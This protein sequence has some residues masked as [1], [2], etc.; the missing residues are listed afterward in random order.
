MLNIVRRA[1]AI[2]AALLSSFVSAQAQDK[3]TSW[4]QFGDREVV[5]LAASEPKPY[6]AFLA[7]LRHMESRGN[8]RAVNTLN[9]LGAYQFG[10]AAL[11]DLGYVRRDRNI[12]DNNFGGGFTG[13]DGI[14]SV[15]DFLNNPRVQ[16]KAARNWVKLMW[17]YIESEGLHRY[18]W[19]RTGD[20]VLTPSG[21]L[22]ATH[23][24]GTGG[25]RK[26]IKSGGSRKIVDP[27]GT[28]IYR[29]VRTLAGYEIP[30]APKRPAKLASL[31]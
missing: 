21:M 18:A 16:D 24:L 19:T 1:A 9:F 13:K 30:F 6:D 26:F 22:G 27:Y 12:S 7:E 8:Y 23:L 29:Y 11:I 14:R 2:S 5:V 20:V 10:E 31:N 17:H 4:A 3:A 28:P 25:L 15:N